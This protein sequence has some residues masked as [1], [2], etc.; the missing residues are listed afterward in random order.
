MNN[1]MKFLVSIIAL[2]PFIL[3]CQQESRNPLE[4][5][6]LSKETYSDEFTYDHARVY[7]IPYDKKEP[8]AWGKVKYNL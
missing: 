1:Q 3:G 8:D 7:L 5:S 2:V 6:S 4:A